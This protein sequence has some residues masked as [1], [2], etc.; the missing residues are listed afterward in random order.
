M[1]F[2]FL[3]FLRDVKKINHC[4]GALGFWPKKHAGKVRQC[5]LHTVTLLRYIHIHALHKLFRQSCEFLMFQEL[6]GLFSLHSNFSAQH[7]VRYVRYDLFLFVSPSCCS[8]FSNKGLTNYSMILLRC[9]A[10]VTVI[11]WR[12]QSADVGINIIVSYH[13]FSHIEAFKTFHAFAKAYDII[14]S[15]HHYFYKLY[16]T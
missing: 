5:D 11:S 10:F 9:S 16:G 15:S 2:F 12:G 6:F 13:S 7:P 3:S 8:T 4:W 1:D 14:H